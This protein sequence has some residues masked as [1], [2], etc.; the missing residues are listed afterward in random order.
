[1]RAIDKFKWPE[2]GRITLM[3]DITFIFQQSHFQ[4]LHN[5][6]NSA[7]VFDLYVF[8]TINLGLAS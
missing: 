5:L 8:K 2:E 7:E 6:S 1:M 4:R 3:Q